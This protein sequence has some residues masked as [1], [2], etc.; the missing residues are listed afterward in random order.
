M[1]IP[2]SMQVYYYHDHLSIIPSIWGWL[3]LQNARRNGKC[4]LCILVSFSSQ[5]QNFNGLDDFHCYH[6]AI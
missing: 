6:M 1:A 5:P 2:P 4:Q 3:N